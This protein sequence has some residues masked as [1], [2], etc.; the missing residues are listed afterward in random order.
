MG[1]PSIVSNIPGPIDVVKKNETAL[2]VA[3]HDAEAL[4]QAMVK[5]LDAELRLRLSKNAVQFVTQSF[6]QEILMQRI[7]ERKLQLLEE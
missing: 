2:I 7:W 5:T 1:T 6:D 4:Y 3:P